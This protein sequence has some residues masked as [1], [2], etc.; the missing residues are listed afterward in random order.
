[1]KK[2][3]EV[4]ATEDIETLSRSQRREAAEKRRENK[5]K[6]AAENGSVVLQIHSGD[7]MYSLVSLIPQLDRA[8]SILQQRTRRLGQTEREAVNERVVK[9]VDEALALTE[10]V[11]KISGVRFWIPSPLQADENN[12]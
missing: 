12:D 1:M 8:L 4:K 9:F 3:K 2:E 6:R 5:I 10:D 11:C 7:E